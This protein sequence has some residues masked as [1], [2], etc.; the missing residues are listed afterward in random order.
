MIYQDILKFSS[1]K[2]K[3]KRIKYFTVDFLT[4]L[5]DN[6]R[7]TFLKYISTKDSILFIDFRMILIQI[8]V[9]N[10]LILI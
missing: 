3:G 8:N 9:E 2:S 4:G 1:K 7:Q 6:L 10:Y 5:L